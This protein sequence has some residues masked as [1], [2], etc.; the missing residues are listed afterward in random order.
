LQTLQAQGGIIDNL[1]GFIPV[2][3]QNFINGFSF[4]RKKSREGRKNSDYKEKHFLK[5]FDILKQ[6]K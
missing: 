5:I 1:Y 6:E 4:N 2:D 3:W